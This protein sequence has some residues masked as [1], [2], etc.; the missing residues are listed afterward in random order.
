MSR[1]H[2]D[3]TEDEDNKNNEDEDDN[4]LDNINDAGLHSHKYTVKRQQ[5]PLVGTLV[6][7]SCVFMACQT[8]IRESGHN[9]HIEMEKFA[10]GLQLY[11]HHRAQEQLNRN[12]CS[13][14][15]ILKTK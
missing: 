13:S 3:S 10:F 15:E 7:L 6:A 14:L 8:S 11:L 4:Y 2:R 5:M 1:L 9:L 12:V